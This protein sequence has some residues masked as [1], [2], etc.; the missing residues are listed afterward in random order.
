[1][2]KLIVIIMFLSTSVQSQVLEPNSAERQQLIAMGADILA[3]E[4]SKTATHFKLGNERFFISKTS[5]RIAIGRAF[6]RGKKLDSAQE[7]ELYK[8]INN[9]NMDQ[10]I[11][12]VLYENSIQANIFYY[13]NY[14]PKVMARLILTASKIENI[15]DANPR[16]FE[17]AN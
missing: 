6:K 17:L 16:I 13:G 5:E 14:D 1:M 11:Q 3:D 7:H 9:I 8:I 15:F 4:T 12:F 2:K 10:A